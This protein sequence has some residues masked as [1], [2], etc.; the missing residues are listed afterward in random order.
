[1]TKKRFIR[2]NEDGFRSDGYLKPL[3]ATS[4][5][6]DYLYTFADFDI[7]TDETAYRVEAR[8]RRADGVVV[9]P[10][11]LD[12]VTLTE[13]E[14]AKIGILYQAC[15]RL[16][17][18]EQML[19]VP[20][21]LE[22]TISY[23]VL[24]ASGQIV[25]T[26]ATAQFAIMVAEAVEEVATQEQ[27]DTLRNE[28][29][30]RNFG[31][32]T[33][34]DTVKSAMFFLV[35]TADETKKI[36]FATI[37]NYLKTT[38]VYD[39][40]LQVAD[41]FLDDF[42]VPGLYRYHF[43][44]GPH[45]EAR[46]EKLAI[47]DTRWE[48]N[49]LKPYQSSIS[50][51]GVRYREYLSGVWTSWQDLNWSDITAHLNDKTNPHNVTKVQINLGN[52]DDKSSATIR[53]EITVDNIP[54]LPQSKIANLESNLSALNIN[55]VDKT[56]KIIGITLQSDITLATFKTALGNATTSL[57]GLM[58]AV[59]KT[60]LDNLVALLDTDDTDNVVN[61][62][63]EILAIF[64]NYP[65]G[66]NVLEALNGKVDK[67]T[68]KALSTND[69]DN[70][71]K[72]KVTDAHTHSQ[73]ETGNPHKVTAAEVGAV[74]T[75]EPIIASTKPKITY[76]E[77]GLVTAGADLAASD[78]P[79]LP[80][81][82]IIGLQTALA[83]KID[84][85]YTGYAA[86][87]IDPEVPT[88]ANKLFLINDNGE[89][90]KLTLGA[91]VGYVGGVTGEFNANAYYPN[92]KVGVADKMAVFEPLTKSRIMKNDVSAGD[93]TEIL[94]NQP[95]MQKNAV[96]ESIKGVSIVQKFDRTEPNFKF[97]LIAGNVYFAINPYAAAVVN[98]EQ[99][100]PLTNGYAKFTAT[101]SGLYEFDN[102]VEPFEQ[103][104]DLTAM[105]GFADKTADELFHLLGHTYYPFGIT[106]AQ[107]TKLTS[108]GDNLFDWKYLYNE[109]KKVDADN[110]SIVSK[111]GRR[112]LKITNPSLYNGLKLYEGAFS[113]AVRYKTKA[114]VFFEAAGFALKND[115][116]TLIST[117][118]LN[119]WTETTGTTT[120]DMSYIFIEAVGTSPIYLNLD[121]FA[122]Y[123]S[124]NPTTEYRD[125]EEDVFEIPQALTDMGCLPNGVSDEIL[126]DKGIA[127][128]KM[129]RVVFAGSE[130]WVFSNE[131][132][133]DE[134][135]FE[136]GSAIFG[137]ELSS[138][139]GAIVASGINYERIL[140]TTT[141]LYVRV[142]KV[143]IPNY[144]DDLTD[145][146]K[147]ELFKSWLA[148]R[149]T[150]E[151]PLTIDYQLA[152]PELITFAPVGN[153]IQSWNYG[154]ESIDSL[155]KIDITYPI[156]LLLQIN[157]NTE[158]LTEHKVRLGKAEEDIADLQVG[159]VD[160]TDLTYYA[161][162]A[163][164][165][166]AYAPTDAEKNVQSDWNQTV[167]TEDDFIKNK[168]TIPSKTS[169]LTND[170]G[171]ATETY[172][173]NKVSAVYKPQGS[174][175]FNDLVVGLLVA[176]NSGFVYNITDA[177]TTNENF[178]EGAGKSH[179]AGTNVVIIE[180]S[181]NYKFDVL[182]G[183][184]DLT[185]Y[186]LLSNKVTSWSSTTNDTRYPSEKLVKDSLDELENTIQGVSD[187]SPYHYEGTFIGGDVS[188]NDFDNLIVGF[189]DLRK[190]T[191]FNE[192]KL[193]GSYFVCS[194]NSSFYFNTTYH[195]SAAEGTGKTSAITY[196]WAAPYSLNGL[197]EINMKEGDIISILDFSYDAGSNTI[198]TLIKV[199]KN[200]EETF[201]LKNDTIT[202]ATKA[203]ITYDT[204]GLV[205][206]GSD[207]SATDIPALAIS[208]ITG[209]QTA[210]DNKVDKNSGIVVETWG[211]PT[212]TLALSDANK[213]FKCL[214]TTDQTL[215]IPADATVAFPIG[216]MIT[217][218]LTSTYK[219]TFTAVGGVTLTSMDSLVELATQFA[220]ASLIKTDTNTWH[221]VGV[222]E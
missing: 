116:D 147:A 192:T 87:T 8:L 11:L 58:S 156:S 76:D 54:T 84:K 204:K 187:L 157:T 44:D 153:A 125:Y 21:P 119:A 32:F 12:P 65:E 22:A 174:L 74:A 196:T 25:G 106:H 4:A 135:V 115:T 160:K 206:S 7:S 34:L 207:L 81:D 52:V 203:K 122:L 89:V 67:V 93:E 193:Q 96:V 191:E 105:P 70:T 197:T 148:A 59:D 145:I 146:Q 50:P 68:G 214:Y 94:D 159:K 198:S 16:R 29:V 127:W 99:Q 79:S 53:S 133:A 9:G 123:H 149:N 201:V 152:Q 168:P 221:L 98:E 78:I 130:N 121:K 100:V 41:V 88:N 62:I 184:V 165:P 42:F 182:G 13:T 38:M 86:D 134:I 220:M 215:T 108:V 95:E 161:K 213:L 51:T 209:L 132:T 177:F 181:G 69:Y 30:P 166:T 173:N 179:S 36:T 56:A 90:K 82:K 126:L 107:P 164:L 40:G 216:T 1:M 169:D 118:T 175:A 183:T 176:A 190:G 199:E 37:D 180:H 10:A 26:R 17:F 60:H 27:W 80:Q 48:A 137:K 185:P 85:D 195:W 5:D 114:E 136:L 155:V 178:V 6:V 28:F 142:Y 131:P 104:F 110:V 212:K 3:V 210:L 163:D 172:V 205:T 222:L 188:Q 128:K 15:R 117:A 57:D 124:E 101:V 2:F 154:R 66:A 20:G 143:D 35:R 162:T 49:N 150:T 14:T 111:D 97:N 72:Q 140:T 92:L 139:E 63:G 47:I 186:E 194:A 211:T 91:L 103:V 219:V 129:G 113:P 55:K 31:D 46:H 200:P 217:F 23:R 151:T 19:K 18:D 202:G 73:I 109:L 189:E 208:K 61:T 141:A 64:E 33:L 102:L 158:I 83:G 39:L 138:L 167:N 43:L 77:K 170:S 71:E 112:C 120:I 144:D 171:F 24:N 45:G 218:L 75:N